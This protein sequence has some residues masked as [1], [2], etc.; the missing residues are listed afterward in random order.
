MAQRRNPPR[1]MTP[2][3]IIEAFPH[4]L[5]ERCICGH[6]E[7]DLDPDVL[8]CLVTEWARVRARR[9]EAARENGVSALELLIAE[10][11]VAHPY[12]DRK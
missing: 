4:P 2:E 9:V 11:G 3:E 10:H 8:D 6:C 12:T 5:D 7:P 1:S